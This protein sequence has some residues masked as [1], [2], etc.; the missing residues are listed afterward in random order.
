MDLPH[1]ITLVELRQ[2]LNS[3]EP[4]ALLIEPRI[5]RR[6]IRLDRRLPGLGLLVPHRKCY[7][8]DRER[9]LAFVDWSELELPPGAELPSTVILLSK[10]AD[11]EEL[12]LG[13]GEETLHQYWRLLFHARVHSALE[14]RIA[15]CASPDNC[16][17][18]RRA[19][20]GAVEFAEIRTVLLQDDFLFPEPNDL[21][22]YIEFA[23]V[24]LE[25]RYFAERELP[26]YFPAVRDWSEIDRLVRQDIDHASLFQAT[27]LPGAPAPD[28]ASVEQLAR[29][30][31][32]ASSAAVQAP[33]SASPA[34]FE[35]LQ[36]KANRAS[37]DGNG[38]KAAIWQMRAARVASPPDKDAAR[39]QAERE[40][41]CVVDRLQNALELSSEDAERWLSALMPLLAPAAQGYWSNEA[42][43]LYDLQKVC[44]EQERGVFKLDL[45]E[46]VRGQ[47]RRPLRRSLPVLREA[48]ISR[49]LRTAHR[50]TGAA[51]IGTEERERLLSLLSETLHRVEHRLRERTRP[52]VTQIFDEVGLIPENIPERV[53]RRKL[54]EE[55]LDRVVERGYLNM[56]DLRD[57]LSKND[58][59]LPDVSG[60]RDLIVGDRLLGADRELSRALDG[61]YRRGA[62]YLRWPQ[63]LSSLAFGTPAGRWLTQYVAVPFGGAYLA[64]EFGR[65]VAESLGGHG[66]GAEAK[67]SLEATAAAGPDWFFLTGVMLLGVAILLLIH[68]AGFREWSAALIRR[69]WD[70]GRRLLIEL[71]ARLVRSS[72]V[73]RILN[74]QVYAAMRAYLLRP[75]LLTFL[76]WL[77][78][79]AVGPP[80]SGRL[81]LE[82]FLASVIFLNSPV[83][84][85]VVEWLADLFARGWHELRMRVFAALYQW[86]MDAFRAL[87]V[88]LERVIYTVDEWLRFRAGDSRWSQ[89]V[90]AVGGVIWFFAAYIVV[91]VFT[92]LVEPQINPIKHFPVV[93]VSHKLILPTGP[94]FVQ[95]FTPYIGRAEAN[96]LVW[97]TIWLIPGVFGF[98][99]WE[100]KEN[101][102]L[103]AA[104]RPR[105]LRPSSIG[106]HGETMT[107]LLRPGFHS[108]T[109]PKAFASLRRAARKAE[110]TGDWKAVSRKRTNIDHAE[111]AVRR[112]VERELLELLYES[113]LVPRGALQVAEVHAAT[114]RIDVE[115]RR[116]G[117][118]AEP[119]RMSWEEHSGRL[120]GTVTRAGWLDS[121][122]STQRAAF[123]AAL[124]GLFQRAGVEQTHGP[125]TCEPSRIAWDDWIATWSLAQQP[126][127][128]KSWQP[129]A[130]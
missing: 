92:L 60:P 113:D 11:E 25:L 64:L 23:A 85:F 32:A 15:Q 68:N 65:H 96:T 33:S 112:F 130:S 30:S 57:A 4:A 6:V 99:V 84:R 111:E 31:G 17:A 3:A 116:C 47:G 19:A 86:T 29:P 22:T 42:R 109:L 38:V 53:A 16:A 67:D 2:A 97:T 121:L 8:V 43:L 14:Q 10:P 49:R 39:N 59:K 102:R 126:P 114:N 45:I 27:W 52:V 41:A 1:R 58:L 72:F 48:L 79:R 82:I 28:G 118:D 91:F 36:A 5:L 9:L 66:H 7:V 87:F 83:G 26:V 103:Y 110:R 69:A 40:L 51:R 95:Q 125:L 35:R 88:G 24:H 80:W 46:W 93:T 78:L 71:P 94:V 120:R 98:L 74:S 106:H 107:R 124:A 76:I 90:K 21:E 50:R 122:D 55:L 81:G 18:E 12:V 127:S 54:I 70:A 129:L 13:R 62:V 63:T 128:A 104:N 44:V 75:V 123:A 108:G 73:Q 34:R 89:G 77:P 56:G 117:E 115:I 20:I 119:A 61:V 100:L 105:K 101:W 37:A